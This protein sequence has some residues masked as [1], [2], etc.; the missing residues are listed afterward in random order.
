MLALGLGFLLS[1]GLAGYVFW[2]G[3]SPFDDGSKLA[4]FLWAL[5][6][7]S[8]ICA[9]FGCLALV[10]NCHFVNRTRKLLLR[11]LDEREGQD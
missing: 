7:V 4:I 10:F 1:S 11:L 8:Q 5:L 9:A 6:W 2:I 3:L